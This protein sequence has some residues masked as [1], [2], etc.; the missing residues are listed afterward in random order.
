MKIFLILLLFNF[1]CCNINKEEYP[2]EVKEI[3][4]EKL[5]DKTKWALYCIHCDEL[6]IF[7]KSKG[8]HDSI[9]F[10]SLPL[11]LKEVYR[12]NDTTDFYFY[13]YYNDSLKCDYTLINNEKIDLGAAYFK[14]NDSIIYYNE[15]SWANIYIPGRDPRSRYIKQLQ[16]EVIGYIKRNRETLNPWFRGE[17][18]KRGI[19][20]E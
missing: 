16:P 19:I 10:G 9:T 15:L 20:K 7:D 18:I 2:K 11:K 4:V 6:C 13:F 17:A 5:Y 8:I 3:K 1:I 14:G 12:H